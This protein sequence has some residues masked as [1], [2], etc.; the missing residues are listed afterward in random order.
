MMSLGS[1]RN[2]LMVGSLS[3]AFSCMGA[4]VTCSSELKKVLKMRSSTFIFGGPV[5]PPYLAAVSAVCEILGSPEYDR[6]LQRLH[7]L[8]H[9]LTEGIRSQGLTVLGGQTPIISVTIG[10]IERTL[11]AG[12]WL[13]DRGYYVQSTTYPAVPINGGLL[14][15]QVNA[16]HSDEAVDGLVSALGELKKEFHLPDSPVGQETQIYCES[17]NA[18]RQ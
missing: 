13:F 14:R 15:I 8:I 12:K 1:L 18:A 3:K 7:V 17:F 9:R 16:N 4:F 5:P 11:E 6:I 10:D 2:V